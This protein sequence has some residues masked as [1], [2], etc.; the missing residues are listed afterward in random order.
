MSRTIILL[1]LTQAMS[2]ILGFFGLSIFLKHD[3]Y[4]GEPP[5]GISS[6]AIYHWSHLTL[7]LRHYG[8]ILLLVPLTW[9]AFVVI[10]ESRSRFVIPFGFWMILGAIIP[11][12]IITAFFYAIFHPCIAVPYWTCTQ[13]RIGRNRLNAPAATTDLRGGHNCPRS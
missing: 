9:T 1:G 8:F 7:F 3:G 5:Q 10:S 4:P 6:F 12:A 13:L 2:V 11:V